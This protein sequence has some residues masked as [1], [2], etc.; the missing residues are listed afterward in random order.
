MTGVETSQGTINAPRVLIC[1]GG[2]GNLLC[3]MVGLKLPIHPLTIQ[4]MVTQPLKPFLDHVVSSGAYH[5]YANQT[6]KGEVAM[7]AHM[8][9]LAQLHHHTTPRYF[10]H[11][12]R[13]SPSCCPVSRASS[14]CA[15]GPGWP[16]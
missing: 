2:Y 8:G 1:A 4:A 12:A 10:K 13:R 5:V 6:L 7:G 14:S 16:T 15:I 9:P 3:Q 11:Q